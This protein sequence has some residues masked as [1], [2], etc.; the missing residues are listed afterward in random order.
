MRII[1]IKHITSKAG[2][3]LVLVNTPSKD[4]FI[5]FGQ[6][7]QAGSVNLQSYVGGDIEVNYYAKGEKLANGVECDTEGVLV[8]Q[9]FPTQNAEVVGQ[10]E[11]IT[12]AKQAE[13][14]EAKAAFMR[15]MRTNAKPVVSAPTANVED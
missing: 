14:Q 15:R 4:L 11:A 12:V 1:A 3:P 5:P 6:W 9:V 13:E 7:K 8:K 10:V 2:K